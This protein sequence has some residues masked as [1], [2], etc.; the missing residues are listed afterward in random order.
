MDPQFFERTE[1]LS[2]EAGYGSTLKF[3]NAAGIPESSYYYWKRNPDRHPDVI[4]F[5]RMARTLG[6][7]MDYLLTGETPNLLMKKILTLARSI[8]E[9]AENLV[10]SV[11]L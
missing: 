9:M 2:K 3:L 6:C 1:R 11:S 10:S 4:Q 5:S 8:G 7:S